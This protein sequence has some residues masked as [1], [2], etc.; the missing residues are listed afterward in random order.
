MLLSIYI[1]KRSRNLR[2]LDS[3]RRRLRYLQKKGPYIYIY[4]CR[5]ICSSINKDRKKDTFTR[6]YLLPHYT[7]QN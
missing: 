7:R 6:L 3:E 2:N 4:I 1:A 5:Y